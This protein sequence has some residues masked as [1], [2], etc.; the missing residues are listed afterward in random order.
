[1][2][3]KIYVCKKIC[4]ISNT[5]YMH[6]NCSLKGSVNEKID[7]NTDLHSILLNNYFKYYINMKYTELFTSDSIT[8]KYIDKDYI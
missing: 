8:M 4:T 7:H 5:N 6:Y 3:L 1:M 2:F